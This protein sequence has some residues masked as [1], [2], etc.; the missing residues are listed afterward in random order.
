MYLRISP[1][2]VAASLGLFSL[3][4]Q[5][6]KYAV[7]SSIHGDFRCSVPW[8][9]KVMTDE[10]GTHYA[11]TTFLGPFDPEFYLGLPTLSVRWFSYAEPHR[12]PDGVL[13]MYTSSGDYIRQILRNVY[14]PKPIMRQKAHEIFVAG[15]KARHF[16]VLS[17]VEVPP[18]TQWGTAIEAKTNKLVNLREH[19]YVVL[20]LKTGFY[21]LIYPATREGFSLYE[22]QFNVMVNTF[23]PLKEGPAGPP[24][25]PVPS[26]PAPKKIFR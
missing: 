7:Y 20:P 22:S 17:A 6:P 26:A 4:C 16:V 10:E 19:A 25:K 15:R 9:W 1:A 8:G 21:V 24:I 13:E 11:N 12:L 2:M 14:G 5:P 18:Q 3:G 23:E